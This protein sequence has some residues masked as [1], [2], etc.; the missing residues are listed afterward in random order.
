[1]SV[2]RSLMSCGVTNDLPSM[3]ALA[4]AASARLMVARGDA[5]ERMRGASDGSAFSGLR[6]VCTRSTMY[7]FIAASM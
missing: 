7:S 1:M 6:V 5:P 4:L 3:N 2:A